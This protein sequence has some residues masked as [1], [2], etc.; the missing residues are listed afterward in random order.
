MKHIIHGASPRPAK[1][2]V[3]AKRQFL[4]LDTVRG[5]NNILATGGAAEASARLLAAIPLSGARQQNRAFVEWNIA[6]H[7]VLPAT[8]HL[9]ARRLR[10]RTRAPSSALGAGPSG[11]LPALFCSRSQRRS[12]RLRPRPPAMRWPHRAPS[13]FRASGT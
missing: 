4:N 10:A 1:R 2:T 13:C 6:C 12:V 7:A 9:R 11:L 5:D 3:L 8:L